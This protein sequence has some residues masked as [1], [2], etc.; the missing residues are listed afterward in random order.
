MVGAFLLA[1]LETV[2]QFE[3]GTKWGS[4]VL[5]FAAVA[6]LVLRPNGLFGSRDITRN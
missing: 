1:F 3:L 4:P 6:M 5:L 2:A